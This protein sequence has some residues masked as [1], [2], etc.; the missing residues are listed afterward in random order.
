MTFWCC[1]N[2]SR[3]RIRFPNDPDATKVDLSRSKDPGLQTL[4]RRSQWLFYLLFGIS[5]SNLWI[6]YE[7]NSYFNLWP[8]QWTS[9][10]SNSSTGLRINVVDPD[11]HWSA[12]NWNAGSGSAIGSASTWSAG[13]GSASASTCRWQSQNGH[14]LVWAHGFSLFMTEFWIIGTAGRR[15][16][17]S[18]FICLIVGCGW[19]R[20]GGQTGGERCPPLSSV[21][22]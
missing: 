21:L 16:L 20:C 1:S 22:F 13:A 19:D 14:R 17:Y 11:P 2:S 15:I 7:K 4:D 18:V 3:G 5:F 12:S 9:I 10:W 8:A 6:V